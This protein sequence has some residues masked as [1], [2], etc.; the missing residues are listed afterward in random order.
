MPEKKVKKTLKANDAVATEGFEQIEAY[1]KAIGFDPQK[2]LEVLEIINADVDVLKTDM[3]ALKK[4]MNQR[5]EKLEKGQIELLKM[6]F[7]HKTEMEGR[8]DELKEGNQRILNLLDKLVVKNMQDMKQEDVMHTA[9]LDR[10]EAAL[11]DHD[12]RIGRLEAM[13]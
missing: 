3:A 10:H 9:R 5:F 7:A 12:E 11:A 1:F 8:F 6:F 2:V 4:E 13:M